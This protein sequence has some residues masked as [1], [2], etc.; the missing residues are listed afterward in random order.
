MAGRLS[1]KE[2]RQSALDNLK[3]ELIRSAAKRLFAT[4]GLDA[5]SVREIA[6]EAGYTTGAIYFH[7]ESKEALYADILKE[8]LERLYESVSTAAG[9][10]A[11]PLDAL[12]AAFRALVAFYDEN[13]RDLDLSLYLLQ[14][15]QPRGLTPDANWALNEQL[16]L[17]MSV[18]RQRLLEA[19]VPPGALNVEV[20][21]IFDEMIGT[22]IAAHTGR[23]RLFRVDLQSMTEHHIRNLILRLPSKAT[24]FDTQ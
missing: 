19:G 20:A 3:R 23:M 17:T 12:G 22:L 1:A 18:Y 8:S 6:R 4:R 11:S 21:G 2:D 9:E 16:M 14:G 5:T 15:T 13:P 24:R 7:Y 10:C